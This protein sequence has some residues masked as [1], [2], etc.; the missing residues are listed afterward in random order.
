MV[1][2]TARPLPWPV[3][4]RELEGPELRPA[5]QRPSVTIVRHNGVEVDIMTIPGTWSTP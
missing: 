1:L 5:R 2:T 3:R 4:V